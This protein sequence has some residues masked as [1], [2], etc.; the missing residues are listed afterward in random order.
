MFG[1]FEQD[2]N[3][4]NGKDTIEWRVLSVS[5][6]RALLIS[7]YGLDGQ[8][9]DTH[10]RPVTWSDCT[11]RTWLNTTFL[12]NAFSASEQNAIQLTNVDNGTSQGYSGWGTSG[13][14]DT[15]DKVFLLS[16]AEAWEYFASDS[17]RACYATTYALSREAEQHD[18]DNHSWWWLR[19]PGETDSH[20]SYVNFNGTVYSNAVGN[21]YV[22]VRPALW[23]DIATYQTLND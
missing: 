8:P 18:P 15:Q 23:I 6:N 14:Q 11:L 9:F 12:N 7:E 3:T 10:Y 19:S 1:H 22:S 20:A 17:D 21:D 4:S 5:G 2:G 13:G 16:Y